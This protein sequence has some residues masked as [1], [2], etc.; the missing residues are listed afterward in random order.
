MFL[1]SK[2]NRN[3]SKYFLKNLSTIYLII[4]TKTY[5][6]KIKDFQTVCVIILLL[7]TIDYNRLDLVKII[8]NI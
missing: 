1:F 4:I 7:I 6:L 2:Y 8:V 5:I 3:Y